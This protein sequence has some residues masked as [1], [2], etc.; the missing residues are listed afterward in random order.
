MNP[1]RF[2]VSE[3]SVPV[4]LPWADLARKK[5]V[6]KETKMEKFKNITKTEELLS[7]HEKLCDQARTLMGMKNS[8]YKAGS[9]DPFANFR[10][11]KLAHVD[12]V[13]GIIVRM[14][15]KLARWMA[16]IE[17]G[18]LAVKEESV[19]DV[20]L[21]LINYTVISAGLLIEKIN[22]AAPAELPVEMK[23]FS[24]EEK[25]RSLVLSAQ[26]LM[27]NAMNTVVNDND[28]TDLEGAITALQAL[29]NWKVIT[30]KVAATPMGDC[31]NGDN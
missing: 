19:F 22:A 9:G 23:T 13:T 3:K 2:G 1:V 8:D 20:A 11:A 10:M 21:D 4:L 7:L 15:D 31:E 5:I 30:A 17:K 18:T 12:E 25:Y 26:L 6:Y 14:M 24:D 27:G 16:F 28:F 29:K